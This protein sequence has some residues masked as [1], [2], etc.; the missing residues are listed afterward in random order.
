ME[1]CPRKSEK[2]KIDIS[3]TPHKRNTLEF[4]DKAYR[5][6]ITIKVLIKLIRLVY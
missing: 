4:E 3:S 1:S 6:Y 2:S 5:G